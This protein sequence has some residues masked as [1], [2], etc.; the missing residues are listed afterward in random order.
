MVDMV[1]PTRIDYNC[2]VEDTQLYT[3]PCWSVSRLVRRSIRRSVT[4][5]NSERF[6]HHCSCPTVRDCPAVYAALFLVA[7][8]RLYTLV[9]RSVGASVDPLFYFFG[10]FELFEPTAPAQMLH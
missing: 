8:T 7:D 5:L 4:F 6:L 3:L 10:V 2:L 9:R 1:F